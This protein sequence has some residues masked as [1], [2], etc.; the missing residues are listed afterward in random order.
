LQSLNPPYDCVVP[1][2]LRNI[3]DDLEDI[4]HVFEEGG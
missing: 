4:G 2:T 1:F 3:K